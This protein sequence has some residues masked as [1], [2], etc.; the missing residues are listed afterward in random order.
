MQ[1]RQTPGRSDEL[2]WV[3]A[4]VRERQELAGLPLVISNGKTY[5][6]M[7][8]YRNGQ[9]LS[10][11][12]ALVDP[13]RAVRY[14]GTDSVDLALPILA[15]YLP[16]DVRIIPIRIGASPVPGLLQRYGAL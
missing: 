14:D 4:A 3:S 10:R 5:L 15:Q 7:A 12:V 1:H 6:P 11:V 13:V 9:Q 2:E 16:L 8:Y